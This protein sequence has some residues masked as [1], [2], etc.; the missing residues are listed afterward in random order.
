MTLEKSLARAE[1]YYLTQSEEGEVIKFCD[2]CG[3][4][5]CEGDLA[6]EIGE[7]TYCDGCIISFMIRL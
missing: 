2:E 7:K 6:Y 1:G 5:L 4:Y 3:K